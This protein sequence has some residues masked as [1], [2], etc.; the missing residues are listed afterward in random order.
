[1]DNA[2]YDYSPIVDREPIQWPGGARVAFYVGLNIEHFP[3]DAPATSLNEATAGLVPDPLN[4]GWRDYGPRVGFWRIAEILDRH[5]IRA[6]A[7][8]NSAVCEKYPQLIAAGQQ[9]DWAWLAHGRDNATVQSA[10][11]D[12]R[13]YLTD[14][15]T[16]I[17]KATGQRPR[18]WLGPALS[19]TFDTPE[20][21]AEL[22][23]SYLL[24]WTADD[25]PF[26]L[27]VPGLLSVP[28]SVE[29][30]DLGLFTMKSFTGPDFVQ[31]VTDQFDQLYADSAHSGRVMALALHPFVTGQPYRAKYLDQALEYIAGHHGVWLTTSDEIAE[32]YAATTRG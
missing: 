15:V 5:G 28:Y 11:E 32:H 26:R 21:L 25:Q 24:D 7:L 16:T 22:G 23:L 30:N 18:G 4:H 6:S 27:N 19:E 14:V 20:I 10:V 13:A 31:I 8:V 29:L 17:E 12:E 1:M 3:V 2:L 9:R